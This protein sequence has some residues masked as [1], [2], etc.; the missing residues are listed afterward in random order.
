MESRSDKRFIKKLN[1]RNWS[2]I[3][4]MI[5][6]RRPIPIEGC[7]VRRRIRKNN[8][9]YDSLTMELFAFLIELHLHRHYFNI[10]QEMFSSYI[11]HQFWE[12]RR[13]MESSRGSVVDDPKKQKKKKKWKLSPLLIIS[14][15]RFCKPHQ[16]VIEISRY[17]TLLD[18]QSTQF[19]SAAS[20]AL[21]G[22]QLRCTSFRLTCPRFTRTSRTR[23]A[24]HWRAMM[25]TESL[26]KTT[27]IRPW[28]RISG[29]FCAV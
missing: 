17:A 22:L 14:S 19:Q 11:Y 1:L 18:H 26:P 16:M 24:E 12:D 2:Q 25:S 6:C 13:H 10:R 29:T 5:W 20:H 15:Q 7:G 21:R 4:G 8:Q 27:S 9:F 23:T 3:V 28:L